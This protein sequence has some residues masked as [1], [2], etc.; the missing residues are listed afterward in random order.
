MRLAEGHDEIDVELVGGDPHHWQTNVYAPSPHDKQ[1]LWGVYG[2]IE[3][4]PGRTSVS[5]YH[6]Y[7]IDWSTERII[8]S[9]DGTEVRTLRPRES[10]CQIRLW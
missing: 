5:E 1:P 3:D 7:T 4:F 8:W 2:E 10:F 6:N 9:V